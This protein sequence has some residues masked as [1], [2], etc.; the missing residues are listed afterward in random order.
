MNFLTDVCGFWPFHVAVAQKWR[1]TLAQCT[2]VPVLILSLDCPPNSETQLKVIIGMLSL[3][4]LIFS[5][6]L[7]SIR[8]LQKLPH[9]YWM[10]LVH[11]THPQQV[12][13]LPAN[14]VTLS[15][16]T[17]WP[18]KE[19]P[20]ELLLRLEL[21]ACNL[22]MPHLCPQE[23][24]SLLTSLSG[25]PKLVKPD[26]DDPNKV[27]RRDAGKLDWLCRVLLLLNGSLM[28][29]TRNWWMPAA[30]L[31]LTW[32]LSLSCVTVQMQLQLN[33]RKKIHF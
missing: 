30:F 22:N 31:L 6:K 23:H 17:T 32:R 19:L 27:F 2:T 26:G 3:L 25:L 11:S 20:M 13:L 14:S 9:F 8:K 16:C 4:I 29:A 18:G 24:S 28:T 5:H 7:W 21:K 1:Q 33:K 15:S 12:P 10:C